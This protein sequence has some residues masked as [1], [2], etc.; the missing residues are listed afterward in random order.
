MNSE[1]PKTEGRVGTPASGDAQAELIGRARAG[2]AAA[3]DA[4]ITGIR[5]RL[6]R[7]ALVRLGDPDEADDVAQNVSLRIAQRISRFDSRASFT[8][9]AFTLTRNACTDLERTFWRRKRA[10]G[11]ELTAGMSSAA[12]RIEERETSDVVRAFFRH[13]P[14]R[15]RELFD[16]VDLQGYTAAEA[17]A[18]LGIDAATARTHLFRA[19]RTLR[20]RIL[21]E[22]PHVMEDR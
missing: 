5:G 1:T 20:E 14:S 7:W 18:L 9:W 17:A 10:S 19:R 22:A 21:E 6:F 15:Q 4:L 11:A 16:L 12:E 13:L 2:D 3:A 8:T